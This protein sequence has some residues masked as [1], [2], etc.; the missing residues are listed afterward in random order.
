MKRVRS[1]RGRVV[2]NSL[3]EIRKNKLRGAFEIISKCGG[4]CAKSNPF[5]SIARLQKWTGLSPCCLKNLFWSF[6]ERE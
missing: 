2:P 1:Y 4:R 5:Y 3:I 6:G